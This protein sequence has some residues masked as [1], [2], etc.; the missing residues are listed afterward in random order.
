MAATIM[1]FSRVD[2]PEPVT[3][4]IRP[5]WATPSMEYFCTVL[6]PE[7]PMG[8]DMEEEA[9]PRYQVLISFMSIFSTLPASLENRYSNFSI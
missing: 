3:P 5:C 2:L 7:I 1:V 9:S 4:E 6:A 8:T